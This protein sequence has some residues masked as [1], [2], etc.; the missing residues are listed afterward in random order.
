MISFESF[1]PGFEPLHSDINFVGEPLGDVY[2]YVKIKCSISLF[3][4]FWFT[5]S[6][7]EELCSMKL[8]DQK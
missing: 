7:S 1:G 4:I 5:S 3:L 2:M 6:A 8:N